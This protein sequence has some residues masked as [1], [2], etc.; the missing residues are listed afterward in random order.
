[1]V[2]GAV[3]YSNCV[4]NGDYNCNV[5]PTEVHTPLKKEIPQQEKKEKK[6]RNGKRF[7]F[8]EKL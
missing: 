1:M 4:C 2:P 3:K 7:L 5:M 8:T 6:K